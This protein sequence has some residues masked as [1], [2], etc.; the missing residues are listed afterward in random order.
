MPDVLPPLH[1]R[2][3]LEVGKLKDSI[4]ATRKRKKEKYFTSE[5]V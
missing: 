1:S 4:Y 2:I 3:S 5:I